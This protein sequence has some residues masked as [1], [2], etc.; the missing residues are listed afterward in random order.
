M[1]HIKQIEGIDSTHKQQQQT[2]LRV[3]LQV[4]YKHKRPEKDL[5]KKLFI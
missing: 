4:V 1:G 5:K 3:L 2:S